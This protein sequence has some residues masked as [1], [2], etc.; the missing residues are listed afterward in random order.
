MGHLDAVKLLV[1]IGLKVNDK[2][3]VGSTVVVKISYYDSFH[4]LYFYI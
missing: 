1:E 3:V 4:N 2:N